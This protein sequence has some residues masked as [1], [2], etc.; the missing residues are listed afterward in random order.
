MRT[1]Q[2][3]KRRA[4]AGAWAGYCPGGEIIDFPVEVR[5]ASL[6]G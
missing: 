2:F 3:E 5:S 4:S 1:D 6:S